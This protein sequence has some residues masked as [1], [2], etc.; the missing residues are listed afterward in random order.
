M[1]VALS[2]QII[3]IIAS[4]AWGFE[5]II[6]RFEITTMGMYVCGIRDITKE[7]CSYTAWSFF[8]YRAVTH[9]GRFARVWNG[10][11]ILQNCPSAC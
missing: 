7:H 9:D 4:L 8:A 11:F 1:L 5:G 10:A 2:G 3:V 6:Q